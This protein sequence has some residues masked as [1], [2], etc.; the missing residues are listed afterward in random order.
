ME[1]D[2]QLIASLITALVAISVLTFSTSSRADGDQQVMVKCFGYVKTPATDCDTD[3]DNC[4]PAAIE[5]VPTEWVYITEDVC[6][7]LTGM[8]GTPIDP[9]AATI[10][11]QITGGSGK[12]VPAPNASAPTPAPTSPY[13][14]D[15]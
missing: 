15:Y 6:K 2:K 8:S 5:T 12:I 13:V 10:Q 4:H 3:N 11:K 14:N 1:Q 7:R 9:A